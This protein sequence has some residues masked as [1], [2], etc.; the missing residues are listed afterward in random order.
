M[1]TAYYTCIV[2][3][4][5][6]D[7]V[8]EDVGFGSGYGKKAGDAIEGATKEAVTDAL[9][10]CLRTFGSQFGLALYDKERANVANPKDLAIADIVGCAD[11]DSLKS[12]WDNLRDNY[13]SLAADPAVYDAKERRK[14]ELA[15]ITDPV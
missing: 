11:L 6:G 2:R 13:R 9:K 7:V 5:V 8:R 15:G 4:T 3:V 1:F 10:R 14:R 12:I